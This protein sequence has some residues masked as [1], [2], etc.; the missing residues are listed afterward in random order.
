[1]QQPQQQQGIGSQPSSQSQMGQQPSQMGRQSSQMGQQGI[2]QQGQIPEGTQGYTEGA[3]SAIG[4]SGQQG[5][6]GGMQAGGGQMSAQ[7]MGGQQGGGQRELRLDE[8]LTNEMRVALHDLVQAANVTEWCAEQC[9]DD[10]PQMNECLRLC[11]DVA[12]LASLNVSFMTRDS[13]FGLDLI[14]VFIEAADACARECAQHQHGH[15]QECAEALSKAIQSSQQ[16][17][18]SFQGGGQP[19]PSQQY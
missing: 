3:Q 14:S 4:Q 6:Q 7:P 5:M 13:A 9:I 19:Q 16:M 2:Q 10:G 12:D 8:A 15:C 1:M 17:L 11:R 18:S